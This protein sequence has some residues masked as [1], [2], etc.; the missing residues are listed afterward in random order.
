M[1]EVEAASFGWLPTGCTAGVDCD[2]VRAEVQ[3]GAAVPLD[4]AVLFRCRAAITEQPAD[5]CYHRLRC[6]DLAV[7]A[8]GGAI[9]AMCAHGSVTSQTPQP[10]LQYAF[11]VTPEH[12]LVG[13]P[14]E[15][16]VTV[17][18]RGGLP[19]FSL[20]GAEPLLAGPTRASGS[21]PVSQTVRFQL[22]AVGSGTASLRLSVNYEAEV[23]C[24]GSVFYGFV[25][26]VSEPFALAIGAGS[27][28]TPTPTTT[29]NPPAATSPTADRGL[30]AG[31]GCAIQAPRGSA[32]A[33][34]WC[35]LPVAA[36]LLAGRW[37]RRPRRATTPGRQRDGR[38]MPGAR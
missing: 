35:A 32:I 33:V 15:V 10:G 4:D 16:R 27:A 28:P 22:A 36:L 25:S 26:D 6:I 3:I 9:G 18:G 29:P 5:G 23:G 14:V 11:A 38:G 13:D 31:G 37:R 1:A 17:S 24:P 21:G 12:P 7:A 19:A 30:T 8:A 34:A 20:L 2:A